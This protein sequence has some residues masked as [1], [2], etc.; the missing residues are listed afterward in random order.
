[1]VAPYHPSDTQRREAK[2]VPRRVDRLDSRQAEIPD[3]VGVAKRR[4]KAAAGRIHVDWNVESGVLLK[5]IQGLRDS[6]HRLVLAA[7]GHAERGDDHDGI[8]VTSSQRLFRAHQKTVTFDRNL[9]DLDIEVAAELVPA[10]LHRSANQIRPV[11]GF[12]LR[13]H[14]GSP[15][16]FR[17]QTAEHRRFAGAGG[18]TSDGVCRGGR[19]PKIGEDMNAAASISAVCGYS[20]L[21]HI[22]LSMHSAMSVCTSGSIQVV[23]KVARFCRELPSSNS[24]SWMSA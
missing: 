7:H 13:P 20:S 21:S 2:L 16:P 1:M 11:G 17:R 24:S 10:D 18:G 6:L 8:F 14:P 4:K 23:Q 9:A 5:L 12:A 22:F 15:A 19:I 3:E